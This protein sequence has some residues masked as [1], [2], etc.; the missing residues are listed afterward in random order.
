MFKLFTPSRQSCVSHE[1]GELAFFTRLVSV[2]L[3][4]FLPSQAFTSGKTSPTLESKRLTNNCG[5]AS[6]SKE[7]PAKG[8]VTIVLSDLVERALIVTIRQDIATVYDQS[9]LKEIKELEAATSGI[10][11]SNERNDIFL[12]FI[13][14]Q[15]TGDF[16]ERQHLNIISK[17]K[18]LSRESLMEWSRQVHQQVPAKY[19]APQ[20]FFEQYQ[21]GLDS[22]LADNKEGLFQRSSLVGL[23]KSQ[24]K[25]RVL[26]RSPKIR[27]M[28]ARGDVSAQTTSESSSRRIEGTRTELLID[29]L[30]AKVTPVGLIIPDSKFESLIQESPGHLRMMKTVEFAK[31]FGA[32][33][34][35][36][37]IPLYWVTLAHVGLDY[38]RNPQAI[39][40]FFK[41][42]KD[43][44]SHVGF[45]AFIAANHKFSKIWLHMTDPRFH[46]L[47]PYLGMAMGMTASSMISSF[48]HD[49]TIQSCARSH[50][51]DREACQKAYNGWVLSG[52]INELAPSIAGLLGTAVLSGIVSKGLVESGK[53]TSQGI[54]KVGAASAEKLA[55]RLQGLHI[56][57]KKIYQG[58]RLEEYLLNLRK[59]K[60]LVNTN[61]VTIGSNLVFLAVD[62]FV[63]IPIERQWQEWQLTSFNLSQFLEL[64]TPLGNLENMARFMMF[65][66]VKLPHEISEKTLPQVHS[67]LNIA[68]DSFIKENF[69]LLDPKACLAQGT[70]KEKADSLKKVSQPRH[71]TG[72]KNAE[73]ENLRGCLEKSDLPFW[74]GKYSEVQKDWRTHLVSESVNASLQWSSTIA[75]FLTMFNGTRQFYD[76][77]IRNIWEHRRRVIEINKGPGGAEEKKVKIAKDR[78]ELILRVFRRTE[79]LK[80][81]Y[82]ATK[83]PAVRASTEMVS[84]NGVN[85]K[86]VVVPA[87]SEEEKERYADL[88]PRAMGGFNI[89][90]L[91]DF[92]L[93]SMVCG[94][95]AEER[96]SAFQKFTSLRWLPWESIA[97]VMPSV[98]TTTKIAEPFSPV[99]QTAPGMTFEMVPPRITEKNEVCDPAQWLEREDSVVNRI[100][101]IPSVNKSPVTSAFKEK[102]PKLMANA[103]Q[104]MDGVASA[105]SQLSEKVVGAFTDEVRQNKYGLSVGRAF[106][107]AGRE[108]E[109]WRDESALLYWQKIKVGS[110]VY[111]GVIDYLIDNA[112]E[113]ILRSDDEFDHGFV[114]WYRKIVEEPIASTDKGLWKDVQAN[115]ETLLDRHFFPTLQKKEAGGLCKEGSSRC[116]L[117]SKVYFQSEGVFESATIEFH[118][119]LRVLQVILEKAVSLNTPNQQADRAALMT[120]VSAAD[121]QRTQLL[122]AIEGISVRERAIDASSIRAELAAYQ[123]AI[124]VLGGGIPWKSGQPPV[125]LET[126]VA[127]L[128][129]LMESTLTEVEGYQNY[130]EA[131]SLNKNHLNSS[132]GATSGSRRI[133]PRARF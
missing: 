12:D 104:M 124:S 38:S 121:D 110:R 102:A 107:N 116:G 59:V 3:F 14:N 79:L 113:D 42:L 21:Q 57:P 71:W 36:F 17:T 61:I 117:T 63:S 66:N 31:D 123:K 132:Q 127:R 26:L 91:S 97:S 69:N 10:D 100:S 5:G 43:P 47:G 105:V 94:P 118:T 119:Y 73:F 58:A 86:R 89:T 108:G 103:S 44:A 60:G 7:N 51:S 95:R 20:S 62:P 25:Q 92:L 18:K 130:V 111:R 23:M 19:P 98:F 40:D 35:L 78:E 53:I 34:V 93:A 90:E 99:L 70:T 24:I 15:L 27:E 129:E 9:L 122:K 65:E 49:P 67:A 16:F 50:L 80:V 74:L 88:Y 30:G 8:N 37:N 41:S 64:N 11:R 114:D 75:D 133:D 120:L 13:V 112:R 85:E 82:E 115:Y 56:L 32:Q 83:V 6:C 2:A 46:F 77:V 52:K 1:K 68:V 81:A 28:L 55:V 128:F 29:G 22:L 4:A 101:E 39:S 45:A 54:Q 72:G 106:E 126:V 125:G 96:P 109:L 84:A 33:T 76:F 87:R 131:L 48:W